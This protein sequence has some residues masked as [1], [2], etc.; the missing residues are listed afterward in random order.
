MCLRSE[1][2]WLKEADLKEITKD[3][4]KR[5][6]KVPVVIFFSMM[7]M[8]PGGMFWAKVAPGGTIWPPQKSAFNYETGP[9]EPQF[10]WTAVMELNSSGIFVLIFRLVLDLS[11]TPSHEGC[12]NPL[13]T[14]VYNYIML[15]WKIFLWEEL[16]GIFLRLWHHF[17]LPRSPAPP[18]SSPL[19]V[20]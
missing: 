16:V 12:S 9:F 18:F 15:F 8:G 19:P 14:R 4:G 10:H 13:L 11:H 3:Y 7:E 17:H 2:K 1:W 5:S 20:F 6:I